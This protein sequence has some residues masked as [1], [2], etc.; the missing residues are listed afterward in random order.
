[1][2]CSAT[3]LGLA[4]S[5]ASK[6]ASSSGVS[7]RRRVPAIGRALMPPPSDTAQSTSRSG[8]HDTTTSA[9][10]SRKAMN[11]LGFTSRSRRYAAS[12]SPCAGADTPR[13]RLT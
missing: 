3:S 7:P 2:V 6:A 10:M 12:G 9:P 5:S 11:G 1:M 4:R 8:L 13:D